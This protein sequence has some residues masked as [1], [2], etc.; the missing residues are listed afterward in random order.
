MKGLKDLISEALFFKKEN[1]LFSFLPHFKILSGCG[2]LKCFCYALFFNFLLSCGNGKC[3]KDT[4]CKIPM[5]CVLGEC[6]AKYPP[7]DAPVDISEN[8][9]SE[10]EIITP[11]NHGDDSFLVEEEPKEQEEDLIE[12]DFEEEELQEASILWSEDFSTDPVRWQWQQ[13]NW[14]VQGGQFSQNLFNLSEAWVPDSLW[15]DFAAEVSVVADVVNDI[16]SGR[17]AM[18]IL[19][20]VQSIDPNSYYLCEADFKNSV[21]VL[22]RYDSVAPGYH[23]ICISETIAPSLQSGSG[24]IWYRIQVIARETRLGCRVTGPEGSAEI[25]TI[26]IAGSDNSDTPYLRGGIGL[27]TNNVQGRF[28]NLIVYDRRPPEWPFPTG[29]KSCP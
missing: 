14:Q 3:N 16:P 17:A 6:V 28:D 22:L 2:F 15:G 19:F 13:G 4:D 11:E 20:R 7:I 26:E 18:G 25:V 10:D 5:V 1:Y 21:L 23:T 9:V 27:F 29:E 24:N 8:V 12:E